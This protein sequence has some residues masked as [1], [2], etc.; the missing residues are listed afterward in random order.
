MGETDFH[1]VAVLLL[2]RALED[3]LAGR[4]ACVA[5]NM[6]LY[7]RQGDPSGRSDP[8]VM[9]ALGVGRHQRRSFRTWEEDAVPNVV[10]EVASEET[11]EEDLTHKRGTYEQ[12]GV[13][14]YF[15]FDPEGGWLSPTLQG[16]RLEG[17]AY[18][19]LAPEADGSLLSLELGLRLVPEGTRLRLVDLQ[20]GVPVLTRL[21]Q[22]EQERA[23]SLAA[24]R[25]ADAER[26]RAE[27]ER[28]RADELEA[29]VARLR[30]ALGQ[31]PPGP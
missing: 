20:S 10:F 4:A 28:R 17:R 12:V 30:A 14:E 7:F 8:D 22:I 25:R 16:F 5:S 3:H 23:R 21:E 11:F 6:L 27:A 13:R 29:E 18:Q 26:Q 19:A 1:A 9:V 15:L 24:L 2:R 31:A